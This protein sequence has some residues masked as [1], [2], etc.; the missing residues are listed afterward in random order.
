LFI[1]GHLGV[2]ERLVRQIKKD[3]L[4]FWTLLG[5]LLPD[6][7]DKPLYWG[8]VEWT[9][10]RGSD[11]GLISGSRTIGH[12]LVFSG[13]IYVLG[14]IGKSYRAT[15]VAVG[16]LSHLLLDFVEDRLM[17]RSFFEN[18]ADVSIFFPLM[19]WRFPVSPM[20]SISDHFDVLVRWPVLIFEA[21]GLYWLLQ[22]RQKFVRV[23]NPKILA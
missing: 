17:L 5:C 13:F 3:R 19:G 18:G 21:L 4:F 11:L 20:A 6:L 23:K 15:S 9:G 16:C 1:F 12:T 7:I 22:V 8:L 14:T 10:L 2:G